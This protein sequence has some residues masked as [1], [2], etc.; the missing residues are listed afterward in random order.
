MMVELL[1]IFKIASTAI[2]TELG[3]FWIGY[4][5]AVGIVFFEFST[6]AKHLFTS[7][8]SAVFSFFG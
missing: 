6:G 4:A 3:I 2:A 8:A 7:E 1:L 5:V